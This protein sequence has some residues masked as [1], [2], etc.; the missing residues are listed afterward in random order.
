M[1][2]YVTPD[3]EKMRTAAVYWS[4]IFKLWVEDT[5]YHSGPHSGC[6]R[7]QSEQP[8]AVGDKFCSIKRVR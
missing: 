5:A 6:T 3:T 7:E 8:G 4:H 1:A 2:E